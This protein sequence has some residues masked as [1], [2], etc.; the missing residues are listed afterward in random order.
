MH[1]QLLTLFGCAKPRR[2]W[3]NLLILFFSVLGAGTGHATHMVGGEIIYKCLG[4]DSFLITLNVFRDCYNGVPPFDNPAS[5]G[6]FDQNWNY[7]E[8]YLVPYTSDDTL[9]VTLTDPCLQ[10]PPDVCV[11]RSS[12]SFKAYL[13]FRAGGYNLVYQRC[14]RNQLIRNIIDPE[15]TGASFV[16]RITERS[17]QLC[18]NSAYFRQWPPVAIC[19]NQPI[20]FDH[21][22][23]DPD[24]DSLVYR[25]CVPQSG[26]TSQEPIPQPPFAGPYAPVFYVAPVYSVANMLGGIPLTIDIKTGLLTGT[27]NR[28]GNYVVGV[29]VEE[30]RNGVLI[31]STNRDFQYNVADCGAVIAEFTAPAL[32][33]DQLTVNFDRTS[34][35]NVGTLWYFDW[36]RTN[37]SSMASSPSFTYPDTGNYRVALIVNPGLPC[38]D[39]SFVNIRLQKSFVVS[40]FEVTKGICDSTGLKLD[41]LNL[42]SDTVFGIRSVQWDFTAPDGSKIDILTFDPSLKL[43]QGGNYILSLIS[44]SK[45]GCSSIRTDTI[46]VELP[47]FS[48]LQTDLLVCLGQSVALYPQ[49]LIGQVYQWTPALY[50]DNATKGNPICTPLKDAVYQVKTNHPVSGCPG[51]TSVDVS[52]INVQKGSATATPPVIS[53]GKTSNL[54]YQGAFVPTSIRWSPAVTLSDPNSLTPIARPTETTTVY[55]AIAQTIGGC[56]DTVQVTVLARNDQCIEPFVFIPTGFSPNNDKIND[57]FGPEGI[58][59]EEVYW[60]VYD[61]WGEFIFQSS[62]MS[63]RWDG[64]YQGVTLASDTYGYYIKARCVGGGVYEKKG[65]VSLLR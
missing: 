12:Y 3:R 65:N 6:I 38:T 28:L 23:I 4:N 7:I 47:D 48:N 14:C 20:N 16:A 26:A 59:I 45:N 49:A 40:D 10:A 15:G 25:L 18:N 50:L 29:C 57:D 21:G 34:S 55:T 54:S 44:L 51:S 9:D 33:C 52:V 24:G 63:N 43:K 2:I 53:L 61:R 42:A 56:A 5:I 1:T 32:V 35:A 46:M 22:A 8:Q 58:Q 62:S 64:T 39:T 17:L 13:P 19:I 60:A 27:P 30:Y 31:S 11:H 37:L 41:V 36:P